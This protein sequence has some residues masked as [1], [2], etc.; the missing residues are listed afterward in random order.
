M[1]SVLLHGRV[2]WAPRRHRQAGV[3]S[4]DCLRASQLQY[5]TIACRAQHEGVSDA[6][7]RAA[8]LILNSSTATV[9]PGGS[10]L[11]SPERKNRCGNLVVRNARVPNDTLLV[12]PDHQVMLHRRQIEVGTQLGGPIPGA[13]MRRQN[14]NQ[15]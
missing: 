1:T 7:D 2:S 3:N 6:A 12:R 13:A 9:I 8:Q 4:P 15:H 5:S 11:I 14:F 10:T